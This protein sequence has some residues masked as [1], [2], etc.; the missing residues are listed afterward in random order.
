VF[1]LDARLH[2]AR[3]LFCDP[4]CIWWELGHTAMVEIIVSD[5]PLVVVS[6]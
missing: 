3:S 5:H 6:A 4:N 1:G 2:E